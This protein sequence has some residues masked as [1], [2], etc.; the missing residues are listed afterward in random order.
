M[1]WFAP[2]DIVMNRRIS[3]SQS[4]CPG[5]LGRNCKPGIVLR[6][7]SLTQIRI[8]IGKRY[9]ASQCQLL[10]GRSR[11]GRKQPSLLRNLAWLIRLV[12]GTVQGGGQVQHLLSQPE[13]VA[14]PEAAPQAGRLLRPLCRPDD[15]HLPPAGPAPPAQAGE[16]RTERW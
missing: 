13:M 7:V 10:R 11:K 4:N 14:L 16:A 9:D 3:C 5:V 8:G 12:P 1:I 2:F 15:G 6:Y